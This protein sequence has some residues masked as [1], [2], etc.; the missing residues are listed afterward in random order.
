MNQLPGSQY[1]PCH[2][3]YFASQRIFIRTETLLGIYDS[4]FECL[5]D[6]FFLPTHGHIREYGI[7]VIIPAEIGCSHEKSKCFSPRDPIFRS[8][9]LI[10]FADKV[11][12][13]S[14]L[15]YSADPIIRLLRGYILVH[16]PAYISFLHTFSHDSHSYDQNLLPKDKIVISI[17]ILKPPLRYDSEIRKD[18][19]VRG[20]RIQ[21]GQS[22]AIGRVRC[23]ILSNPLRLGS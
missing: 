19:S 23:L 1:S 12:L 9:I 20:T 4:G 17:V 11:I 22:I 6:E 3:E 5:I 10:L 7:R 13:R 18:A 16:I 2:L 21:D 8:E 15:D 14:E